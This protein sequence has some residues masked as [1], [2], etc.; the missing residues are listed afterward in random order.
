MSLPENP[1]TP[2]APLG[3]GGLST[4]VDPLAINQHHFMSYHPHQSSGGGANTPPQHPHFQHHF[5]HATAS[6]HQSH[7]GVHAPAHHH[8]STV[9]SPNLDFKP[10]HI[11]DWYSHHHSVAAVSH[12]HHHH[13]MASSGRAAFGGYETTKQGSHQVSAALP[14]PPSTGHSPLGHHHPHHHYPSHHHPTHIPLLPSS[15]T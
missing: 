5:H 10:A 15:Y 14:T 3:S 2:C 4:E 8:Y 1:P 12:H 6:P 13:M 11:S 7:P 9:P